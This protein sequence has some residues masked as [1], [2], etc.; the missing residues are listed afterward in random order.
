MTKTP[1]TRKTIATLAKEAQSPPK[2][3]V[4]PAGAPLDSV[5]PLAG[6]VRMEAAAKAVRANIDTGAILAAID[7]ISDR[8]WR[9]VIGWSCGALMVAIV[10][11][12]ATGQSLPGPAELGVLA[13]ILFAVAGL[14]T[15]EKIQ[16]VAG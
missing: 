14:R 4:R 15:V 13:S 8:G 9:R 5:Q 10:F 2:G 1:R 7:K 11:R 16:S 12:V 3:F 6:N